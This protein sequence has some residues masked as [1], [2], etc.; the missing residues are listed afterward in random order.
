MNKNTDTAKRAYQ[1]V[2]TQKKITKS[3]PQG[4]AEKK[5]ERQGLLFCEEESLSPEN[6]ITIGTDEAG[7][8]PL[9]GPVCAAAVV[10]GDSFPAEILNDSKKLSEKKREEAEK[11]IKEKAVSYAVCYVSPAEIDNMNILRASLL[12]MKKACEKVL[13]DLDKKEILPELRKNGSEKIISILADGNKT[14]SIQTT[15]VPAKK[16][17]IRSIVKGDAKIHEIM[18][19]SILAKTAR[20]RIMRHA[21]KK[22][23]LYGFAKHKG[24]PTSDHAEAILKYGYC[25]IHRR[26]FKIPELKNPKQSDLK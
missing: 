1:R 25:P 6:I 11:I 17:R 3:S 2:K 24:Y 13:S 14:F 18:A 7:R 8:G 5:T 22:W 10:L 21:D 20:D 9:A 23:P 16:I 26:T 4:E 12:A 15:L 19:A